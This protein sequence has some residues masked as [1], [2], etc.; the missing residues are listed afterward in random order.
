MEVTIDIGKSGSRTRL[1]QTLGGRPRVSPV[2]AETG[3]VEVEGPGIDP[4]T[5]GRPDG[6]ARVG[7]VVREAVASAAARV[8]GGQITGSSQSRV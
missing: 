1:R 6:A 8:P 2:P 3:L 4:S 5:A 7:R